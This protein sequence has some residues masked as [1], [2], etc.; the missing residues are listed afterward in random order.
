MRNPK[1]DILRCVAVVLV[2]LNHSGPKSEGIIPVFNR[3]GWTGVDLFFVLSG[4]LISGLLFVEWKRDGRIRV[5][6]FLI[7]R[8]F[9]IYPSFYFY[10][11][12]AGLAAH[13]FA[14]H[15]ETSAA[16]YLHEVFFLQNY[17]Y[18]VWAHTWSLAVEEHFY[19]LLPLFL[20]AFGVHRVP[21]AF[22][23][24]AAMSIASRALFLLLPQKNAFLGFSYAATNSRMDALFF[25]VL[26]GYLHHFHGV[27]WEDFVVRWK[28]AIGAGSALLLSLAFFWSRET[29]SF[30]VI[31]YTL[32]YVGFGGALVLCLYVWKRVPWAFGALS[33]LGVYSYSIYLWHA[34]VAFWTDAVL[35]RAFHIVVTPWEMFPLY[36]ALTFALG[37]VMARLVEFPMLRLREALFPTKVRD[38]ELAANPKRPAPLAP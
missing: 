7:R 13:F 16:R 24:I 36:F 25:G 35:G 6:R 2:M 15:L 19:L 14:K 18:G 1:L 9:K 26:L 37:I 10:L 31:G 29:T 5:G 4:F 34:P 38:V 22:P 8:G 32:I 3:I 21:R 12:L 23:V 11:I 20:V 33:F 17:I 28:W 27:W 30:A